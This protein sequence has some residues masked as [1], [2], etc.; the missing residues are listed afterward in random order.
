MATKKKLKRKL[1]T[2]R[3][4]D[5]GIVRSESLETFG[6]REMGVYAEE[7]N[8]ARAVPDLIDG[9]KPVQ[10]R[11]MWAASL[12]GKDFVKT[13]RVVGDCFPAGTMV[14]LS[15]G[16]QVPIETVVVGDEVMH[17]DGIDVVTDTFVREDSELYEVTTD[18]GTVQATPDQ[19]FYCVDANGKEVE[20]TP[21]TMKPGDQIK[22]CAPKKLA[23]VSCIRRVAGRHRTYDFEV[24]NRHRFYAN[25]FLVHNCIGRYHPHGDASV[26]GAI[27]TMV[28]A[29]VPVLSG[30]GNWGSLID[31]AAAIRYT[32]CT[33]SNYGWS[34]FNPDYINKQVTSFVPNYDDS[35]F[36]PVSLP[37][38]LP[39][40]LLNGGEGIG[41]GTTTMLPTFTPESVAKCLQRLLKGDKLKA[42]DFAKEL[43]FTYRYG[44]RLVSTRENKKAI[45]AMF[46]GST[47]SVQFESNLE[48]DRDGKAIE[49]DDWPQGLNPLKF[50]AKIRGFPEVDQAYNHKGATGFRIEMKKDHNYAQFDKLVEKVQKAT[51]VRR[52]FKINVTHRQSS[53]EDG[54]VKFDT[55]YLSL[56]VP[57]LLMLWLKERIALEKRSLNYRIDK[58]N[59]AINYSKLLIFA[60][61]KLDVIFAA[62]RAKDSKAHLVAKLKFTPEQA[63]QI[64]D[65]KVRQLSKLDQDA[66]KAKLKEQQTHLKQLQGWLA[67][68]RSKVATDI[69]AVM[70]AISKDVKFEAAKDRKMAVS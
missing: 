14:T 30:K 55:K 46:T 43:K 42:E 7:V 38:L 65:L 57:K 31:P 11:I 70:D 50:I 52:S 39:N 6:F 16:A 62:L 34:F 19:I 45:L 63:D 59:A 22:T 40:V 9:L 17:D 28:Q 1:R 64:L 18:Q 51:Q 60:S 41:V 58:Q 2:S 48:V 66:I 68:P 27:T 25:G 56:S 33:L 5:I 36:E 21:L 10:R 3:E 54:V 47:A 53:I 26:G 24:K 13:A 15:N 37:A 61:T 44:G 8:L 29:N 12:L 67:K 49:I 32:N 35:T 23:T 20:R 69:H 4:G